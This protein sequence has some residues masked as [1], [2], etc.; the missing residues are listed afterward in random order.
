MLQT[1]DFFENITDKITPE[2]ASEMRGKFRHL[3]QNEVEKTIQSSKRRDLEGVLRYLNR[4]DFHFSEGRNLSFD[5]QSFAVTELVVANKYDNPDDIIR[6]LLYRY[7][8]NHYPR[9]K[10]TSDFPIV[11]CIE[12]TSICNLRCTMCFQSDASFTKDKSMQG[13]MSF[14]LFKKVIDEAK[15][16]DLASIVLASRG[17]PLMNKDIYKMIQYAKDNGVLDVKL[18]TNATFLSEEA[19]CKLIESGLDNLVFSI[20]SAMKE[21]YEQIR[22]G[23]KFDKVVANIRRFKEI[24]D[25]RYPNSKLRTR[26]SMIVVNPNQDIE[27]AQAFW[28]QLVDEF[29]Y[30][31]VIDRLEIYSKEDRSEDRPCSLLWERMYVWFDGTTSICDEDYKS[32][33]SPGVFSNNVSLNE[34]WAGE[35]YEKLRNMHIQHQKNQLHPCDK[36]PGF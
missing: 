35:H 4:E 31:K 5:K 16:Y 8:F 26:V 23:A 3:V 17:E 12:P 34:I 27:H 22:V 21:E 20:D 15:Q 11:L 10:I 32:L 1:T 25:I 33:Q 9:Q 18:N 2:M 28:S 19:A 7:R 29:A 24:R 13:M 6:Y 30:R 14:E 36:C